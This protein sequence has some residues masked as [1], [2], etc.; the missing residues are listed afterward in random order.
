MGTNV[1]PVLQM[2]RMML[3]GLVTLD[4]ASLEPMVC[5]GSR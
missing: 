5:L 3:G 4:G 1:F 2:K